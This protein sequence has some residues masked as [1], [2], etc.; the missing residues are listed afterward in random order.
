MLAT[1]FAARARAD[2][3]AWHKREGTLEAMLVL[4]NQI[5]DF[6]GQW[7]RPN[8]A[9]HPPELHRVTAAK[10]GDQITALV[11]LSG[12]SPDPD[13]SCHADVDFTVL[14][15]SGSSLGSRNGAELWH[16]APPSVPPK[17]H[18]VVG[19]ARLDLGLEKSDPTGVYRIRAVVRDGVT[20]KH[21]DLEQ[22]LHVSAA[23]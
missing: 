9:S 20:H 8:D 3:T 11:L 12:C 22:T 14:G 21:V 4:T 13:G 17:P 7:T 15:P 1:S 23:H 18:T 19:R 5:D 6:L 16:G 2:E 10:L